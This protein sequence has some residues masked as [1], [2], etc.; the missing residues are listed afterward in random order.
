[1]K[2][3]IRRLCKMVPITVRPLL[4]FRSFGGRLL[5]REVS[6]GKVVGCFWK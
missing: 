1:M 5:R 4:L 2:G 6:S 3:G